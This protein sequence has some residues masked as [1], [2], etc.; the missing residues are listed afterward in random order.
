PQIDYY[1]IGQLTNSFG[2]IQHAKFSTPNYHHGYCL[3]DN[4]RA[5]LLLSK[6]IKQM[7]SPQERTWLNTYL[8]FIYYMQKDDGNFINF[9]NF[10]YTFT[11]SVGSPDSFGRTIW[12][13]GVLLQNEYLS[14]FHPIAKEIFDRAFSQVYQLQSLRAVAY[15][16]LG[17]H[18]FVQINPVKDKIDIFNQ[19]ANYLVQQYDSAKTEQW[20]W[21]EKIIAYDNAILP[22][23]LIKASAYFKNE[24]M[25]TVAL[26]TFEFLDNILF[27]RQHLSIIGNQGWFQKGKSR[28]EY[29]QQPI[30]VYSIILLYQHVFKETGLQ[31][32]RQRKNVAFLWFF[33]INDKKLQ[34]YDPLTKG[35]CD[36]LEEYGVNWNQGAEST[37]C[38]WLSYLE[39]YA[40]E[41]LDS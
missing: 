31:K 2:I 39:I 18:A 15:T 27:K 16:I 36:G 17:L 6:A 29:G 33:G 22:L 23:A 13:L 30:E 40:T 32:H 12:A 11:E 5:L 20:H 19:L 34:L 38:F 25:R 24:Q 41:F 26:Q 10:D 1:H 21:F 9:I 7:P 28:S 35:C 14:E 37:L 4:C 3:D 8:S